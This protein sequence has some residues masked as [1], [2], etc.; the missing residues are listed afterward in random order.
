MAQAA[1]TAPASA[2]VRRFEGRAMAS[3]L[4]LTVCE[5]SSDQAAWWIAD[6]GTLEMTP[7]AHE[8]TAWVEGEA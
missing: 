4:R 8:R 1:R 7:A 6:D 5:P 3:P 2:T